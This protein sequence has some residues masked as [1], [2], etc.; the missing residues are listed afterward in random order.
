MRTDTPS[1]EIEHL[2]RC[3]NDLV[4][5]LALPAIWTSHEPSQIANTLLA[6]LVRLLRLDFAYV[7]VSTSVDGAGME[8]AQTTGHRDIRLHEIRRALDRWL[9]AEVPETSVVVPN[10]VGDGVV[11]IAPF[12]LG[13]QDEVGRLIVGS[14]RP[15]FPTHV[16]RLLT[17]VAVNEAAIGL[18]DARRMRQQREA[19]EARLSEMRSQ[20]AHAGRITMLG[21]LAASI[22]HELN[23]PLTAINANA[24]AALRVL[25]QPLPDITEATAALDDIVRDDQR[26]S[27]IIEQFRTLLKRS[28]TVREPCDLNATI[29][30]VVEL[31]RSEAQQRQI[32]LNCYIVEPMPSIPGV[33]VQLQQVILNLLLNAF[34]AVT[35]P[36]SIARAVTVRA[37]YDQARGIV[38]EVEDEGPPVSDD[39]FDRM[40]T[41]LYTTKPDGLGLGL[42]ICREILAAHGSELCVNRKDAGGIVFSFTLQPMTPAA[43]SSYPA[44]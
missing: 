31:V 25:E 6:V 26:A 27:A 32:A 18:H 41:P 28:P 16:E 38:I 21:T 2:R 36:S 1:K 33:R 35:E 29:R 23:Q 9:T 4:V 14:Q 37:S 24:R 30:G 15:D 22:A 34:D 5:V 7:R 12:R 10:P 40:C 42:S 43:S 39:R 13:L 19:N 44:T 8:L 20:L 17:Q 3:I 11:S